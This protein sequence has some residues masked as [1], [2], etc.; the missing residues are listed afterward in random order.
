MWNEN[1]P[2][3]KE[4][5]VPATYSFRI[6]IRWC[7]FISLSTRTLKTIN[8][9]N[10]CIQVIDISSYPITLFETTQNLQLCRNSNLH[11]DNTVS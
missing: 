2:F 11:C 10:W 6:N 3:K 5:T 9:V 4:T 1:F 7:A 8:P